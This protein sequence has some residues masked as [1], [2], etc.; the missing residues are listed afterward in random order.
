M[1]WECVV[2]AVA[3]N[4]NLRFQ[5]YGVPLPPCPA[6][7]HPWCGTLVWYPPFA[8]VPEPPCSHLWPARL[9]P[10]VILARG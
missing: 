5:G 10:T 6:L 2:R 1:T 9:Q 8:A 3:A 7:S 4:V